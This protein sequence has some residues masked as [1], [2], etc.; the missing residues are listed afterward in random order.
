MAE[1]QRSAAKGFREPRYRDLISALI[2]ER[3]RLKL[4]QD[5]LAARLN[6]H[7]QFV[8]RYENVERRLDIIE[9]VDV[10]RALGLDPSEMIRGAP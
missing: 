6:R 1:G 3:K 4:S 10:A 7:Q 2:A 5:A 8:S 9:F